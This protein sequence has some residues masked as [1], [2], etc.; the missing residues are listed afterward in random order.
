MWVIYINNRCK[1]KFIVLYY[2]S[3]INIKTLLY[4]GKTTIIILYYEK[5]ERKIRVKKKRRGF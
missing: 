1:I 2:Y 4:K 3:I 5:E